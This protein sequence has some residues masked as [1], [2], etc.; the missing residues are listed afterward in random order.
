VASGVTA[1]VYDA[2]RGRRSELDAR[3]ACLRAV[4]IDAAE[5]SARML[6]LEQDDSL[7]W[8]DQQRLIEITREVGCPDTLRYKHRQPDSAKPGSP[9]V[10]MAT[11]LTS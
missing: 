1:T 5:N 9:T 3:E 11:G 2:G 10:R 7:L 4:V 8:W 6:V